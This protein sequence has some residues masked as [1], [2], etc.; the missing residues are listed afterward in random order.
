MR[1][2]SHAVLQQPP[3]LQVATAAAA[4]AAIGFWNRHTARAANN[5][6]AAGLNCSVQA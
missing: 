3:T 2:R 6:I 4:A 1:L 5:H